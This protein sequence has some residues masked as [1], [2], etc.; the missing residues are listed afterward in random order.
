MSYVK[1]GIFF[2]DNQLGT[3]RS[4]GFTHI[5]DVN[6]KLGAATDPNAQNLTGIYVGTGCI[7]YNSFVE[8][9]VCSTTRCNGMLVDGTVEESQ[10]LF[11]I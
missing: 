5:D 7:L 8:A 4:Y 3:T 11:E 2:E 6:I 1:E 10:I 9:N